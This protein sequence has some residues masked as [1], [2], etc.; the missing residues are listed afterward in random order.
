MTIILASCC[1]ERHLASQNSVG[2]NNVVPCNSARDVEVLQTMHLC[3]GKV[4]G[5][6]QHVLDVAMTILLHA[7]EADDDKVRPALDM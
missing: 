3:A 7:V 5:E 1:P 4:S 2:A 6:V